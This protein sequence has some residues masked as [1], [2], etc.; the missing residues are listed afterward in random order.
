MSEI[1]AD[2]CRSRDEFSLNE[3]NVF[4]TEL[5]TAIYFDPIYENSLRISKDKF[6]SKKRAR[7]LVSE[8]DS[9]LDRFCTGDYIPLGKV[10]N[11]SFFPD[12]GF[13]WNVFLLEHYVASYSEK[14]LLLHIGFN[15]NKCAGAIVKRSANIGKF[16]DLIINVLS[17]SSVQLKKNSALQYLS[18]EGYIARKIYYNIEELLIKATAQRNRKEA[19]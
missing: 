15:A 1:F 8:T 9:T 18:D 16:D 3:L 10:Q 14:Y 2:F 12:T 5:G 6:V 7:F 13:P 4:A 11:F 17:N 19:N